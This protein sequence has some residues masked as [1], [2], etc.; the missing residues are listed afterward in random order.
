[1]NVKP[2]ICVALDNF[3]TVSDVIQMCKATQEHVDCWKVGLELFVAAGGTKI[4]ERLKAEFSEQE[5][6]LDLKLKDIPN[7]VEKTIDWIAH[8]TEV[9]YT[10][11][12]VDGGIQMLKR[13][14]DAANGSKMKLLGVTMLTSL[15]HSDLMRHGID[16][17]DG[18]MNGR[19]LIMTDEGEVREMS[20]EEA[21]QRHVVRMASIASAFVDGIVCSA[22]HN[23]AIMASRSIP[24]TPLFIN[25]GIR[26]L[27]AESKH[28]QRQVTT[29]E[30][31]AQV[32]SHM[33]VV[34]RSITEA[35]DPAI[36]A[37]TI[38]DSMA[39]IHEN[40]RKN[41]ELEAALG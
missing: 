20:P 18:T 31:A 4:I 32:N 6:F 12:H 10:T 37:R 8:A 16:E 35:K 28:D 30:H 9:A 13:A 24:R 19:P 21:V 27:D 7:T 5:I 3:E 22:H 34:G 36:A 40:L 39:S 29:P 14:K 1:V 33:I 41:A 17:T 38:K 26:T 25:P 15:E 23:E 2:K 11:I